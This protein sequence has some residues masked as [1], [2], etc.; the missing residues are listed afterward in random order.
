MSQ[1]LKKNTTIFMGVTINP[2]GPENLMILKALAHPSSTPLDII[3]FVE[4]TEFKLNMVMFDYFWQVMVGNTGTHIGT[5]ILE[6][7]GYEGEFKKQRQNFLSMLKNNA[8]SFKELTQKDEEIELYPT[9]KREIASLPSNV[10]H[11]KFLIMEPDDIKMAIMQLKTKNGHII[12]QYYIDLEKLMKMYVEYTLYFNE[13][14]S[15]R[16]ITNL[17]QMMEEL[18]LDRKRQEIERAEDKESMKRQENYIRSLGVSLED[19]KDQNN[20][21]KIQNKEIKRRLSIAAEDRAPLPEQSSKQERFVLLKRNDPNHPAYYTIRAQNA[22]TTNRIR[23][24]ELLFPG[25]EILLDFKCNPNSKTLY[26]RVKE[27]LKKRGVLFDG[28]NIDLGQL[29]NESELIEEMNHVNDVRYD[30]LPE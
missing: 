16:E 15:R 8:I 24:Q 22:Y 11:S 26:T 9:I 4:V 10:Q 25:L 2:K 18:K 12:R 28:N 27:N 20:E 3:K 21:I 19:V 30:V 17:Q 23:A 13:R 5:S 29:V 1:E 7:F 14:E 6:W